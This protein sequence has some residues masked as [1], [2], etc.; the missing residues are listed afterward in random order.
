MEAS[1]HLFQNQGMTLGDVISVKAI[2]VD[3]SK[4]QEVLKWKSLRSVTQIC[5]FLILVG[6]NH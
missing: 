1:V 6:Y 3:L 5:S 4:V 2:A